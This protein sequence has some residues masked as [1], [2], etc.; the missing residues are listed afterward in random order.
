MFSVLPLNLSAENSFCACGCVKN[1]GANIINGFNLPGL[2][3]NLHRLTYYSTGF[4]PFLPYSI[5]IILL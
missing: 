3:L 2:P 4:N 5:K 1:Q